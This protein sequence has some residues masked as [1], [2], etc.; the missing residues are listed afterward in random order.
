MTHKFQGVDILTILFVSAILVA[1]ALAFWSLLDV[2]VLALSLAVIVM[3]IHRY[4]SKGVKESWSA[5]AITVLVFIAVFGTLIFTLVVLYQNSSYLSDMIS[6]IIGWIKS[7]HFESLGLPFEIGSIDSQIMANSRDM[8]GYISGYATGF[9][10]LVVKAIVFFLTLYMVILKGDKVWKEIISC[11]P[12]KICG[13]AH[14]MAKM[15]TDTLYAIYV[16]HIST[17][18][19][20]FLLAV[21]FFY[22]LGYEHVLFYSV[23]AAIFQLI[24]IIGPSLLMAFLAVYAVS[25]GDYRSAALL[26]FIGYPIVCAL[27]DLYFRPVMMGKHASIHPVIMWIGFFGGL[28]VMGVVGFILGPL[29]LALMVSGYGILIEEFKIANLREI[30]PPG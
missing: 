27:P 6:T 22:L 30:L 14:R 15:S 12:E 5:I 9:P 2:V 26:A 1:S 29:F 10:M 28:A 20:T 17:S 7:V 24:P 18:V 11:L 8:V 23:M 13:V 4:F 19:I 25:L 3:P 21:P 16:V